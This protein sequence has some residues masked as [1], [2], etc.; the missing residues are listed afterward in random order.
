MSNNIKT[1][2]IKGFIWRF[3]ERILAQLVSFVVSVILARI[4][5]LEEYGIVAI[6]NVFITIA[7]VF[8]TSGFGT[9]LIQKKDADDLDFNTVLYFSL[10]LSF[11]FYLI[12]FFSAPIVAKI[13]DSPLIIPV[14]RVMGIRLPI[15]S[16]SSIQQAIVSKKMIFKN[17]FFATIIG[18]IISAVA[19]IILA[20]KGFGVWALVAQNLI[21]LFIDT[22]VLA[23][24]VKW[25][26]KLM[27]SWERFKQLFSYSS[28]ILMASLLGTICDK[29]RSLIIGAKYSK[30]DLAFYNKGEQLPNLISDNINS[31]L[32]SVLFSALSKIQDDKEQIKKAVRRSIRLGSFILFPLM[33]GL[34]I[35]ADKVIIILLTEK[36]ANSIIFVRFLCLACLWGVINS[37]NIQAIKAVGRSD[38]VLKL[39][40]IKKPLYLLIIII[41]SFI[42]PLAIAI[43]SSIYSFLVFFINSFPNK[44][45]INYSFF[46]QVKD[47]FIYLTMC[48]IMSFIVF[49]VGLINLNIYLLLLLQILVGVSIYVGLAFLFKCDDFFYLIN[50]LK[51]KKAEENK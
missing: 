1:K 20:V 41:C 34:G 25:L 21:N 42:S 12:L 24:L 15:S 51:W 46:E 16:I 50:I 36:W 37:I 38:I 26:P 5:L 27:F 35:V 4:L 8:V 31:S 10:A 17:F 44:K 47:I 49:L 7:N 14:L 45:L 9:A 28:K 43:G 13:Y 23:I 39:E 30:T 32:D 3:S 29:L 22:L 19:G 40:F 33:F 18:T 48:I 6:V 11:L 2:T